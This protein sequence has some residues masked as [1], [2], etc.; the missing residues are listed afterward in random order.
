MAS[1]V[2]LAAV[3]SGGAIGAVLRYVATDAARVWLP[4]HFPWGTLLVNVTGSLL[5][6]LAF[7]LL[8]ERG[9]LPPA[10]RSF[11]IIG[12][13]GAFTT[14]SAFSLEALQ[15]ISQGAFARAASYIVAS[16]G[17]CLAAAMVGI[18]LGRAV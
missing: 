14:F 8:I 11:L 9:I 3:A 17:V 7:V 4:A 15:L 1:P 2:E 13:L 18:W 5:M 12:V 16:V 10:W 6:G